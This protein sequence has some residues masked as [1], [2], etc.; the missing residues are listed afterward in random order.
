[1]PLLN[2]NAGRKAAMTIRNHRC[3]G[4]EWAVFAFV[5][6]LACG[7]TSL[8]AAE[9]D[10]GTPPA[11][12]PARPAAESSPDIPAF[13]STDSAGAGFWTAP[14]NTANG[15]EPGEQ[16]GAGLYDRV[17]QDLFPVQLI[18]VLLI[19]AII[20]LAQQTGLAL[21]AFGSSRNG[22]LRSVWFRH[23]TVLLLSSLAFWAYGFAF[24]WGNWFNAPVADGWYTNLGPGLAVLNRGAGIGADPNS[25]GTYKFGLLG[26]KGFFLCGVDEMDVV[27]LC[28][29]MMRFMTVAVLI[30]VGAMAERWNRKNAWLYGLWAT[31]PAC[32]TAN[33][34]WGGGWLA[35]AGRNWHLGHGVV[36]FAGS[37]VVFAMGGV[38]SL[39]GC[40]ALG[41]RAGKVAADK[42]GSLPHQQRNVL[43]GGVLILSICWRGGMTWS[44]DVISI[45]AT[46]AAITGIVGTA[47]TARL[48]RSSL[49]AAT[50]CNGLLSGLVAITGP[51]CFVDAT[52]AMTIGAMAGMFCTLSLIL[53][54]RL[55]VDDVTGAVSVFG[56]SGLW[57]LVSLGLFANGKYGG[58]A[59]LPDGT[60]GASWNGVPARDKLIDVATGGVDGVRGL[61]Y[62][63]PSQLAAQL[64]G[65]FTLVLFGFLV[66]FALFR[67]SNLIVPMRVN[68]KSEA[69]AATS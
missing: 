57:G 56:V 68:E 36:D 51:C 18:W 65:A 1:M 35:Q 47:I 50:V 66:S 39:A 42:P 43:I 46:L 23:F 22:T 69:A 45:N 48:L 19:A 62:G 6:S 16:D 33:W 15:N 4:H 20:M 12:N 8:S 32:V 27:A 9:Q 63:D 21:V 53:L 64:L 58:G 67:A 10:V 11:A 54:E 49:T 29:V 55:G 17:V 37:G 31:F 2:F 3:R 7:G 25:P 41:P 61:F 26:T 14:N 52:G 24:G 38:I 13:F 30:P 60:F 40:I 59:I 34:I 28:I 5:L 44:P